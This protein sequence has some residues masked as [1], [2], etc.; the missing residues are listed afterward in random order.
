MEEEMLK[1]IDK[2]LGAII[3][4]LAGNI[5][6]EK[7]KKDA[8]I[9]L[10]SFGLDTNAIAEIVGTTPATV[11]TRLWEQKKGNATKKKKKSEVSQE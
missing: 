2:K 11:T 6:Q 3:R 8:I 10:A 9:T 5:V 1:S 4:L 7:S